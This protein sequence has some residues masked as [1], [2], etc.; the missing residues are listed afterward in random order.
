MALAVL[1]AC[2]TG[3]AVDPVPEWQWHGFLEAEAGWEH[4]TGQAA[5]GWIEGRPTFRAGAE[6]A[7]DEVGAVRPWHVHHNT[8]AEGGGIVGS[9]GDY[10]RLIVNAQGEA[11]VITDVPVGLD[12]AADYHVNV[13][14]SEEE[15]GVIIACADLE[16]VTQP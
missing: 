2:D 1:A 13:H 6:I 5:A 11:I 8:C 4:V 7:G 12:P 14:L 15:M 9:D 10:P 3:T 16:V